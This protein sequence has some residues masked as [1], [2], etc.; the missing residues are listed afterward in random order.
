VDALAR[1]QV[2]EVGGL[3]CEWTWPCDSKLVDNKDK[4][5]ER[6]K[7]IKRKERVLWVF[8]SFLPSIRSF[9]IKCFTKVASS[10]SLELL[11][12]LK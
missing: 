9:F 8:Y 1:L 11:V 10:P 4:K 3:R 2:D 12:E 6:K 5:E 7:R